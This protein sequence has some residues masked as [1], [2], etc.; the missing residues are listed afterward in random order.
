MTTFPVARIGPF[1]V[2]PVAT[3]ALVKLL[4]TIHQIDEGSFLMFTEI[5]GLEVERQDE[6]EHC[7][8]CGYPGGGPCPTCLAVEFPD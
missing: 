4:E 1:Y 6:V 3:T 2:G 8:F 5:L 7:P